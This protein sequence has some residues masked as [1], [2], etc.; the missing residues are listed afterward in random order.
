MNTGFVALYL[1]QLDTNKQ[2]SHVTPPYNAS[3]LIRSNT[4]SNHSLNGPQIHG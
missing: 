2:T 3:Q 4:I 1:L